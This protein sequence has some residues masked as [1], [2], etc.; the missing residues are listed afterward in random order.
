MQF[1]LQ[2]Q[3]CICRLAKKKYPVEVWKGL[4]VF[5]KWS[6]ASW[7]RYTIEELRTLRRKEIIFQGTGDVPWLPI[8]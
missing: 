5:L 2:I 8:F 3:E 7:V 1:M 6:V 4:T